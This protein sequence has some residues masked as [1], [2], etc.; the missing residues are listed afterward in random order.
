MKRFK[1][2]DSV[3]G[4]LYA[5]GQVYEGYIVKRLW[6]WLNGFDYEVWLYDLSDGYVGDQLALLGLKRTV[7]MHDYDLNPLTAPEK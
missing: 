2:G 3:T 4:T 1:K 7:P 5:G 6:T